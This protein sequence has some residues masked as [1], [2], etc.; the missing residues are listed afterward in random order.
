MCETLNTKC[1][2]GTTRFP[3]GYFLFSRFKRA[4]GIFSFQQIQKHCEVSKYLGFQRPL[5]TQQAPHKIW[6]R[7]AQFQYW[8]SAPIYWQAC[9]KFPLGL[10]VAIAPPIFFDHVTD[11]VQLKKCFER[12]YMF[13]LPECWENLLKTSSSFLLALG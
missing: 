2:A 9:G 8:I 7:Q 6:L 5:A 4:A 10:L 3:Q 13:M 11:A 12:I 1:C